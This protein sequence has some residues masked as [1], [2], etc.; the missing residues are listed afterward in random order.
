MNNNYIT[1][2][3]EVALTE[4]VELVEEMN[5]TRPVRSSDLD[6]GGWLVG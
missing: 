2:F 4:A 5:L 3:G 1:K 6:G